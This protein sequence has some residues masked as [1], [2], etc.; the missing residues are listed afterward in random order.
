[1]NLS[2][3]EIYEAALDDD[4]FN[5]LPS[6]IAASVDARSCVLHWRHND[7]AAEISTHSGYFSDA[8]MANYAAN[9]VDHDLWTHAGMRDERLNR[10]FKTT[11][12]VSPTQYERSVFYNEWIRQMGDDTFYCCGSVMQT[13][14][15]FGIIGLHRGRMQGDFSADALDHLNHHVGHL[16]RMFAIRGRISSL[17]ERRNLLGEVFESGQDAAFVVSSTSMLLMANAAGEALLRAD[18]VLQL[19]NGHV[20]P[21]KD[22]GGAYDR[23]VANASSRTSKQA[24]DG[25]LPATDGSSVRASFLPLV[26]RLPHP[27][28][29]IT[30]LPQRIQPH[31]ELVITRLKSVYGLSSA[32]A[33]IAF[34]LANGQTPNEI[35]HERQAALGTVRTQLKHI[36]SKMDARRQADVV[37]MVSTCLDTR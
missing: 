22:D 13:T 25:V 2:S 5:S 36:L 4:L 31:R 12:L 30:I 11:H 8:Q 28:V 26:A 27:A 15:G 16:R 14:H 18:R 7:G 33:D 21:A 29:L 6:R 23:A 37:R 34:R 9:F 19:R 3:D 32:E 35:S 24:A 10:A 17:T 20:R 1:M